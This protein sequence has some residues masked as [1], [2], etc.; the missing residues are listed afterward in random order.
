VAAESA[1]VSDATFLGRTHRIAAL[2]GGSAFVLGSSPLFHAAGLRQLVSSPDGKWLLMTWP[3]A[4]QWV[5][6]RVRAPHTIRAFSGITRQFGM[7]KFPV[8]AGWIGK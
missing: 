8:V 2:R 5:F 4:N 6:V 1:G 3:A 7:G